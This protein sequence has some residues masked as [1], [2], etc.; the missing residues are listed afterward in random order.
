MPW[1]ALC[2]VVPVRTDIS[3]NVSSPSSGFLRAI[4]FHRFVTVGSLLV[5]LSIE[6]YNLWSEST[7]IWDAFTAVSIIDAF[8]DFLKCNYSLK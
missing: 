6:E 2:C 3:E 7:V 4:G 8:R 5:C 1:G